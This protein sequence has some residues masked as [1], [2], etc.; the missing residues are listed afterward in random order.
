MA[1]HDDPGHG[2]AQQRPR[3]D[4]GSPVD[5]VVHPGEGHAPGEGVCDPADPPAPAHLRGHHGRQREGR[6]RVSGGEGEV[7]PGP[8]GAVPAV[9]IVCL[10]GPL[11]MEAPFGQL[12]GE[13]REDEA[14]PAQERHPRQGL[15]P[16]G[17]G[18]AVE[19]HHPGAQVAL[20]AQRANEIGEGTRRRRAVPLHPGTRPGVAVQQNGEAP[21]RGQRAERI[22]ARPG[23][24]P[25]REGGPIPRKT[26]PI[27]DSRSGELAG[28]PQ[29]V[30]PGTG[31]AD[32]RQ[33]EPE[34]HQCGAQLPPDRPGRFH[35]RP[36]R[37]PGYPCCGCVTPRKGGRP[38]IGSAPRTL[39]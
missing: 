6:A 10:R 2:P 38:W 4:V 27:G 18:D 1:P 22:P 29:G 9:G 30:R 20:G 26:R 31:G 35:L 37:A 33:Q 14:L 7:L 5:P 3:E 13:G 21:P 24:R 28:D 12:G 17:E 15:V 32:A 39:R 36:L 19:R 8:R 23:E 34:T 25:G 16:E 11:P